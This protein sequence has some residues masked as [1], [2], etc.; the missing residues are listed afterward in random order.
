MH[1][2]CL[3]VDD[4]YQNHKLAAVYRMKKQ[5]PS[6]T[7]VPQVNPPLPELKGIIRIARDTDEANAEDP[8]K[9]EP[10]T[11]RLTRQAVEADKDEATP[12]EGE[13]P[14]RDES[15]SLRKS[16][17]ASDED[18]AS[19]ESGEN[20]P[21]PESTR[22]RKIRSLVEESSESDE[23]KP[24]EESKSLRKLR[25]ISSDESKEGQASDGSQGDQPKLEATEFRRYRDVQTGDQPNIEAQPQEKTLRMRRF[26]Q[27]PNDA[28]IPED[29]P[30]KEE[31][32]SFRRSRDVA[33]SEQP[34]VVVPVQ[35]SPTNQEAQPNQES[36]NTQPIADVQPAIESKNPE[37][38]ADSP[39]DPQSQT[40][41]A[42][43]VTLDG[44]SQAVPDVAESAESVQNEAKER[45]SD[46]AK[47]PEIPEGEAAPASE[48]SKPVSDEAKE[49]PQTAPVQEQAATVKRR[50][51][52]DD[53]NPEKDQS[54]ETKRLVRRLRQIVDGKGIATEPGCALVRLIR[55]LID[56]EEIEDLT[57][58]RNSENDSKVDRKRQ[59]PI[60]DD[61][62]DK[63]AFRLTRDV[64]EQGEGEKP[65]EEPKNIAR[66]YRQ[67]SGDSQK[68][69][70]E[71][72]SGEVPKDLTKRISRKADEGVYA[73]DLMIKAFPVKSPGGSNA[74]GELKREIEDMR[75]FRSTVDGQKDDDEHG[76]GHRP[77]RNLF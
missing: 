66:F 4:D 53:T 73:I 22:V 17:E 58:E 19:E 18:K 20:Q 12:P 49:V 43:D 75:S 13:I 47:S 42:R 26:R 1:V 23:N 65:A 41:T 7:D 76:D 59:N 9:E 30:N 55:N 10:K 40:R 52:S 64:D 25:D 29:Q 62:L 16:R 37:I 46:I 24:N 28:P 51:Q 50:R 21:K 67:A 8:P 3:L 71:D 77:K 11:L 68:G 34:A 33:L 35:V 56:E 5:A 72:G 6:D 36:A 70:E 39:Q 48:E 2:N 61:G 74:G 69:N 31:S 57:P 27:A 54:Q 45:T 44:P 38:S 32:I 14:S 15:K 60:G 63:F